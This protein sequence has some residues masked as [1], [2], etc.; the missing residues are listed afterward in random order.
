MQMLNEFKFIV[1]NKYALVAIKILVYTAISII[2]INAHAS[3]PMGLSGFVPMILA[4]FAGLSIVITV[5]A[6]FFLY[7][8][9]KNKWIWWA[10]PLFFIVIFLAGVG[11]IALL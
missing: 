7:R 1:A 3:G 5:A 6:Q 11:L 2:P 9:Y 10:F 8:K 4:I